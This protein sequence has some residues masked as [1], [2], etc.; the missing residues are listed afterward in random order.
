MPITDKL[1]A[2]CH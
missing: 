1:N 2:E